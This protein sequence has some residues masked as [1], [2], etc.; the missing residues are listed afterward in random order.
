MPLALRRLSPPARPTSSVQKACRILRSLTDARNVRLTDIATAAGQDMATTLRL[1]EVLR[2]EG[3]VVRDAVTKQY[4]LGPE[5]W[6]LYASAASRHD[7]RP[8]ARP[9][10]ER[11]AARFEDSVILSVP[12]GAESVCVDV[13]EGTFPIRANYLG[14][15][16]RRPLGAGAGSLALLAWLPDSEIA[17]LMPSIGLA[18]QR[19]PRLDQAIVMQHVHRARHAGYAM[20][21]D[22]VVERMGGIGVPVTGPDGRPAAAISIAALT[23]RIVG[24]EHEIADALLREAQVC[25]AAIADS[26]ARPQADPAAHGVSDLEATR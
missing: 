19:Y 26:R 21:L 7:F 12:R 25:S 16:S 10:L 18:L 23:D 22:H 24:R 5:A 4:A 14:I 13:R 8:L 6:L 15:G 17:S 1:L 2:A 11:L 20:M 3:L 9:S